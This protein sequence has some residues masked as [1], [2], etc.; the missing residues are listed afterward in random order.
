MQRR[1][2]AE[3]LNIISTYKNAEHFTIKLSASVRL[4]V[5]TLTQKRRAFYY[6]TLC[7]CASLRR[8]TLPNDL[9]LIF[10]RGGD[11]QGQF[12]FD[13]FGLLDITLGGPQARQSR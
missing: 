4:C 8:K 7:V 11:R 10:S 3:V 5:K 9:R 12:G 1:G 2:D 6:K 13:A